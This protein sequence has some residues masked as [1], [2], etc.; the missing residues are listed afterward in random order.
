MATE[1]RKPTTTTEDIGVNWTDITNTYDTTT[2][3]DETTWGYTYNS[4]GG[5]MRWH[6][7]QTTSYSYSA[8]TLAVKWDTSGGY[9]DD[10][11][12][13]EYSIDGGDNWNVLL[14][15]AVHNETTIQTTSTGLTASQ[16]L[17][18]LQV[19]FTFTKVGG[20]DKDYTY[21]YDVWTNG[22]YEPPVGWSK[23]INGISEYSKINNIAIEN[24]QKVNNV[25]G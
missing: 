15:E 18:L 19:R 7:W 2:G 1:I 17:S 22:G 14:P 8:L 25:N 21:M 9:S 20:G 12:G 23:I 11:F 16:D 3:G 10:T 5:I 6:T 24:I 4:S 13:Y